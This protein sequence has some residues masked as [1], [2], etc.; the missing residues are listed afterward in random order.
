MKQR[1]KTAI[2]QL[3]SMV[4]S[5]EYRLIKRSGL[6]DSAYYLHRARDLEGNVSD[7]LGHYIKWGGGELRRTSV[8]FDPVYYVSQLPPEKKNKLNPLVH[9]L[10]EGWL[11]GNNPNPL[12][13]TDYYLDRYPEVRRLKINPLLYYLDRGW[14]QGHCT[15]P[16]MAVLARDTPLFGL[17]E[18]GIIPLAHFLDRKPYPCFDP[19]WYLDQTPSLSLITNDYWE[20][21][22]DYGV[23]EGKSPVP[24]FDPHFY[25]LNYPDIPAE[26]KDLYFHYLCDKRYEF[27]RPSKW[28]DPVFYMDQVSIEERRGMTPLEH[29]LKKGVY[30]RRYTDGRVAALTEKPL[31]SVIVPVY[32]VKSHYLNNCIRSVLYQTYPHWELCLADDCSTDPHVRTLLGDWEKKDDRIKVVYLQKNRGISGATGRAAELATGEYLAFLDNDDELT[33]DALYH[34]VTALARTDA[35]LVYSDE[36]LIGDDGNIFSTFYKPDYNPE[37]LRCHNYITHLLVSSAVLF[38]ESGGCLKEMDGAQD[39][40]LVLKLSAMA[41]RV[42]HIDLVLYHWRASETSTNINHLQK[43]YADFAGKRAVEE[44]LK[45]MG[46]E[47]D[48]VQTDWKFYYQSS[49]EIC[50]TPLVSIITVWQNNVY[51]GVSWIESLC[52]QT[53]YINYEILVVLTVEEDW[54]AEVVDKMSEVDSRVR[55]VFPPDC[56][57][58]TAFYNSAL[59]HISGEYVAFVSPS[60]EICSPGWLASLLQFVQF[61]DT[62]FVGG[63]ITGGTD[64]GELSTVPNVASESSE[65]YLQWLAGSSQHM[66]GMQ[67]SQEIM[68]VTG[69]LCLVRRSHLKKCGGLD[70]EGFPHL[71][72][73]ADLSLTFRDFG[74]RNIFAATCEVERVS[75]SSP[76]GDETMNNLK[77]VRE[78]DQFQ[79]RWRS[80]LQDGDPF[81]NPGCYRE[82]NISDEQFKSWYLRV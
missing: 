35:D 72:A 80:V 63:A 75:F 56:G 4:S 50:G 13:S 52:R 67:C 62:G 18:N 77:I 42:H 54:P 82:K 81:Y 43:Q 8:F 33:L 40:D 71:F 16:E 55:I 37:L 74:L 28:F 51:G 21:Y 47:G 59:E 31:I 70:A 36:D 5:S 44:A 15:S 49:F 7:L 57:S 64:A 76:N 32:N 27:E 48:V 22:K 58:L 12:F 25:R 9:F 19:C 41:T 73:F 53:T 39:Y 1:I 69:E 10:R 2:L 38:K 68:M 11:Q 3:W 66:N 60:I 23:N 6:F 61:E 45:R 30:E 20:H 14:Q 26:H 29:Y 65:Y 78:R 24:V 17:I 46:R 34:V 79:D